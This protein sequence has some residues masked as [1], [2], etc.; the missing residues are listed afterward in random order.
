MFFEEERGKERGVYCSYLGSNNRVILFG[1][2][3]WRALGSFKLWCAAYRPLPIRLALNG[4]LAL[5]VLTDIACY[6][7]VWCL[8]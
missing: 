7:H 3:S 8:R 6:G 4:S 1:G 5:V 2:S